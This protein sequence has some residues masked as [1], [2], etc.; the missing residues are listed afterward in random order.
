MPITS[1]VYYG[2]DTLI[3]GSA[4][5]CYNLI[6]LH[7]FSVVNALRN[8]II[9]MVLLV[10]VVLFAVDFFVDDDFRGI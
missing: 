7:T 2:D 8:L 1:A 4:D 3:T 5:Y 6:P 10:L 9:Q